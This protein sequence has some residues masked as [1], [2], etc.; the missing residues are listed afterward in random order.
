MPSIE[1]RVRELEAT[2]D[3]H[4][5]MIN[6]LIAIGERQQTLLEEIQRDSQQTQRLWVRLAERYGWLDDEDLTND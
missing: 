2:K 3:N 6:L 1:E 4:Q 5:A